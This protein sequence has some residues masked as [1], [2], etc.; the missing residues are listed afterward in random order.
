M[1]R[2]VTWDDLILLQSHVTHVH[3]DADRSL[4]KDLLVSVLDT[5]IES[6]AERP[7]SEAEE[8]VAHQALLQPIVA[9]SVP[10]QYLR[11]R[12]QSFAGI[13]CAI[14]SRINRPVCATVY[15]R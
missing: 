6:V 10:I 13:L 14:I 9:V 5:A 11:R 7:L 12:T 3:V 15:R 1:H 8:K 2:A 4:C